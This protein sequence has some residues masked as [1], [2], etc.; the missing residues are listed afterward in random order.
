MFFYIV[1]INKS[2]PPP[3]VFP[4]VAM[5]HADDPML[6]HR[7]VTEMS[8]CYTAFAWDDAEK[9]EVSFLARFLHLM[10][11]LPP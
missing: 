7:G 11:R 5:L 3:P 6:Q 2:S 1:L 8:G 10:L 4:P 9:C